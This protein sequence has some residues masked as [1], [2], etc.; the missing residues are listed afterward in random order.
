MQLETYQYQQA[1]YLEMEFSQQAIRGLRH[2]MKNHLNVVGTFT[3][4]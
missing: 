2:D 3:S 1:Y 4:K